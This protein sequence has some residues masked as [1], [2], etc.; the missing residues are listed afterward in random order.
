MTE[1]KSA[2]S[3]A[4][5]LPAGDD[6]ASSAADLGA[7]DAARDHGDDNLATIVPATKKIGE[8]AGNLAAR[9]A[10]FKRRRAQTKS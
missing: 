5:K 10:A 9:A 7:P 8:S 6:A 2:R 3:R 4:Q 1:H